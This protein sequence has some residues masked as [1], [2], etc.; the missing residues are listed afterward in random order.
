MSQLS[1]RKQSTHTLQ[2]LPQTAVMKP[3]PKVAVTSA[4]QLPNL[5]VLTM[6]THD[7]I[8]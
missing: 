3:T 6:G 4:E 5:L 2:H 7:Y 8:N 1:C